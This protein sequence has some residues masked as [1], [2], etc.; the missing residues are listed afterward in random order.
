MQIRAPLERILQ[1]H[2]LSVSH[3]RTNRHSGAL[4]RTMRRRSEEPQDL[5]RNSNCRLGI[6]TTIRRVAAIEN[7]RASFLQ[8]GDASM[9]LIAD[10]LMVTT[11]PLPGL[12]L[13]PTRS[14][15]QGDEAFSP[16]TNLVQV[17]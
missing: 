14:V 3:R 1:V 12:L 10:F 15:V 17:L 9:A 7:S 6:Q 8:K 4:L 13:V 11:R 2:Q 5:V 16:C